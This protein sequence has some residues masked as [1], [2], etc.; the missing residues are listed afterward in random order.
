MENKVLSTF[1]EKSHDGLLPVDF[2]PLS[3]RYMFRLC[4]TSF[5]LFDK[6]AGGPVTFCIMNVGVILPSR[7]TGDLTNASGEIQS[8]S[9]RRSGSSIFSGKHIPCSHIKN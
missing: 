6:S 4:W 5:A 8:A 9:L 2:G 7:S 1:S 3:E